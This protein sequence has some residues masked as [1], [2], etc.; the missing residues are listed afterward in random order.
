VHESGVTRT[1][2]DTV[3]VGDGTSAPNSDGDDAWS[4]SPATV[5]TTPA[6]RTDHAHFAIAV[7][8]APVAGQDVV[9]RARVTNADGSPAALAPWLGMAGHSLLL[10]TDGAVFMHLHA[11][12]TSS[13]A[14]QERLARRG[15]GDTAMHGGAQPV[16]IY[17]AAMPMHIGSAIV[18]GQGDV[19]FP[20]AFPSAGAYRVFV[21]VRRV[22]HVIETAAIDVTV[23]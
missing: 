22:G 9:I 10:R 2:I 5:N 16:A 7:E 3:A 15:Q 1:F 21:E 20:V 17:M 12:G 23:R 6:T 19:G 4:F 18:A 14:A 8:S 11:M 13:M